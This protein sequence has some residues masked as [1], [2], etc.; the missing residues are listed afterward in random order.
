M[1]HEKLHLCYKISDLWNSQR[2]L[3]YYFKLL[4]YM[5]SRLGEHSLFTNFYTVAERA[6][7]AATSE[8]TCK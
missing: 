3:L 5:L 2:L 4:D 6:Q 7:R 1:L 8:N